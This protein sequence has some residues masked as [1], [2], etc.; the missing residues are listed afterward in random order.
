VSGRYTSAAP[1]MSDRQGPR[2]VAG[3]A[4]AFVGLIALALPTAAMGAD[5]VDWQAVEQALGHEGEVRDGVFRATFPRTDLDV[6]VGE[7]RVAPGLALGSW[8]AIMPAGDQA[9][10]MG[11]LVLLATEV[12]PVVERLAGG[13][14]E[15]TALHN[16]LRRESPP[17]W[18]LHVGG[19]GDPVELAR[20]V[21]TALEATRSPLP[22]EA[23]QPP[24]ASGGAAPAA[25]GAGLDQAAIEQALGRKGEKSGDVLKFSIP[26]S[27]P[28]RMHGETVPPSMGVATAINFQ[29]APNGAATTGD[30]VLLAEEVKPVVEALAKH[31]IETTALHNHMLTEEPRLFF[32]H[33]WATGDPSTL[34]SGLKAALARTNV[35]K[36]PEAAAARGRP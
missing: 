8:V 5:R 34:A 32:M 17:L 19:H 7:V 33:F 31:G 9:M 28:I 16:H 11:D 26:R 4:A 20:A 1:R 13:P 36:G 30:L 14:V 6:R 22:A 12:G 25:P 2:R 18:Y 24:S 21:R 29:P 35:E 10:L 15:M 27:E 23:G 3:I